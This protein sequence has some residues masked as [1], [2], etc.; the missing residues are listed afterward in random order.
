MEDLVSW[1]E[2]FV[3]TPSVSQEGNSAIA[4]VVAE[5]LV[6][7]GLGREIRLQPAPGSGPEQVNV[8]A[9]IGPETGQDLLLLTHLDT[10][11]PGRPELWTATGGDPFR[12][13]RE[14]DRLYGLGAADA[15]VDFACKAF[16]L[17]TIEPRQLRRRVRIVG[18][19]GEEIGLRGARR[20]VETGET[21]GFRFA[22]VGEPSELVGIRAHKG[23][24][25]FELR[26]PLPEV[27]SSER[28]RRVQLE[29]TGASVH[30][31]TPHLGEN[32]IE[33]ALAR[34]GGEDVL[35]VSWIEGG[36]AVNRVPDLCRAELIVRDPFGGPTE[37]GALE[38][39]PLAAFLRAWHEAI[40]SVS[41]HRSEEFD[42][43][44]T[45]GSLGRIRTERSEVVITFDLRP[46]PGI[47]PERVVRP[48]NDSGS[49]RCIRVNPPLATS[50]HSRLVQAVLE[51]Q[52]RAGIPRG[53][54]TKATCT[55]AGL[56]SEAGVETLVIG[57]GR[58]VGNVHRP[59]EYTQISQLGSA[60]EV[61]R[62][63]I[64]RLCVKE[65]SACF[66]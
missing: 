1:A 61:Y 25:V 35:G 45:V 28:G 58:S 16:A 37:S 39:K 56:L 53:L 3:A 41:S 62:G 42:P 48:L 33:G 44:H 63:V 26:I 46:V 43:D 4:E 29:F 22:L 23:Y 24:A 32:A 8:I 36:D 66:S 40:R 65:G 18:T 13:T 51:G 52:R 34:L 55:E 21:N 54:G 5:L 27:A 14:G 20:L 19:F 6:R 15:K 11:P 7:L 47:D 17:G 50:E 12:P 31:S 49:L 59:N 2:R 64:D 9:E 57:P 30:S 60:V 38:A 10:V